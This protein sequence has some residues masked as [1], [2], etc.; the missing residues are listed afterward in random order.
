MHSHWEKEREKKTS[1]AKKKKKRKKWGQTWIAGGMVTFG[2]FFSFAASRAI[3]LHRIPGSLVLIRNITT[4]IK[5]LSNQKPFEEALKNRRRKAS[6]IA[7]SLII[8]EPVW[9]VASL[10][11]ENSKSFGFSSVFV[12]MKIRVYF[13]RCL[14]QMKR[15]GFALLEAH[16]GGFCAYLLRMRMTA[17]ALPESHREHGSRR[18]LVHKSAE[19]RKGVHKGL[20][21]LRLATTQ[22]WKKEHPLRIFRL[23]FVLIYD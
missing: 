8:R 13:F 23:F 15:T 17:F 21:L 19:C 16:E 4:I 14:H 6:A 1:A 20:L 22:T 5:A 12:I 18:C 9:I 7:T 3:P 10:F 11:F 2:G